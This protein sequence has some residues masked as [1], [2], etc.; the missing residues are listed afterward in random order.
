MPQR[1]GFLLLPGF[2]L[3]EWAAVRDALMAANTLSALTLYEERL[4][5]LDGAPVCCSAGRAFAVDGALAEAGALQ[6]LVVVAAR[7]PQAPDA[8]ACQAIGAASGALTLLAGIGSGAGWLAAAGRLDGQRCTVRWEQVGELAER[9]PAVIVSSNL[10]EADGPV[11]SSAGGG[12]ALD[13]ALHWLG[14]RHGARLLRELL[15]HF[16]LDRLRPGDER[17]AGNRAGGTAPS[18]KL[19][20]ALA[21]MEANLAE[22]LATEDIAQLVGVSRRQLERLF[23]QHLD[24]L[25]ARWYM[26]LRLT[27]ARRLLQQTSQSILQIGLSCGFASGPHFSRAYRAQ[28]GHTPRDERAQRAAAWRAAPAGDGD[29]LPPPDPSAPAAGAPR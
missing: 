19:T 22:P 17:Q 29:G 8:A 11:I 24:E 4:L 18:G 21:L 2:H 28:F 7:L 13:L 1:I 16:G 15:A 9:H 5:S 3:L 14:R 25:P 12:A 27:Q 10:Y 23:K 26:R 20:E 6:G